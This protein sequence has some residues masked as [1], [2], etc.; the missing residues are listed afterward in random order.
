MNRRRGAALLEFAMALP[1]ALTL[2]VGIS[3]FTIYFWR[4]VQMEEIARGLH[5]RIAATPAAYSAA[6]AGE[7]DGLARTME[8]D[9]RRWSGAP[10]LAV[11]FS[12]HYACPQ[13]GGQETGMAASPLPCADQRVYLRVQA[14]QPVAPLFAP[15]RALG[16]PAAAFSRHVLRLR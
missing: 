1:F 14:E 12:R 15:L 6:T 13:A 16:Y 4:Q 8:A 11:Q 3:D 5:Q 9:A 7:L 2:F 10:Q